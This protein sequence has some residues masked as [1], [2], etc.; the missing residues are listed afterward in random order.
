M[1]FPYFWWQRL[2]PYML[3]G[4]TKWGSLVLGTKQMLFQALRR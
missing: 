3:L 2:A 1:T 4:R